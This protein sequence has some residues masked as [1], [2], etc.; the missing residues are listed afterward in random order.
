MHLIR[1]EPDLV[2]CLRKWRPAKGESKEF[3]PSWLSDGSVA[4][5]FSLHDLNPTASGKYIMNTSTA[6]KWIWAIANILDN[7]R[8]TFQV[9]SNDNFLAFPPTCT[10]ST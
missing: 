10:H 7:L 5:F 3:K 6:L 2:E 1:D 4:L 9:E 8:R